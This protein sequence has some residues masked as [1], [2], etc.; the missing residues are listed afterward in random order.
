MRVSALRPVLVEV[1]LV[2]PPG[3]GVMATVRAVVIGP[4]GE[5]GRFDLSPREGNL[6]VAE[7]PLQFPLEPPVG[8]WR[9][10]VSVESALD[11]QGERELAFR[12]APISFR[13]LANVL[14]VGATLRVPQDFREVVA[15]GDA[16][17]GGRVWRYEEGEVGLWWAPGP[18]KPLSLDNAVMI[19]E[20]THDPDKPPQVLSVEEME[21]QG[22][23][24]FLFREEWPSDSPGVD[25]RPAEALVV[26]GPDYHLYVLRVRALEGQAIPALMRLV[27]ETFA[28]TEE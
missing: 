13:D 28:L 19:L 3:V 25:G 12:P 8:E 9:V 14:P 5:V 18:T 21:W 1:G 27:G 23:P 22:R 26:Q 6:Y 7:E 10:L 2:P 20:A 17:A 11:V 15:Q 24:A 16:L 4:L